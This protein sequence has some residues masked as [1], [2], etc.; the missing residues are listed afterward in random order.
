MLKKRIAVALA[1]MLCL[2]GCAATPAGSGVGASEEVSAGTDGKGAESAAPDGAASAEETAERGEG[3]Q[4]NA[5][6][7]EELQKMP[8]AGTGEWVEA[9]DGSKWF[10]NTGTFYDTFDTVT[11]LIAYTKTEEEFNRF[12]DLAHQEFQRL[13]RLYDNYQTYPGVTNLTTLNE[14]AGK[15]PVPVEE[16]LYSLL[17]FSVDQYEK[18]LGFVNVAMGA[19]L[20][21]WHDAR[22]AAGSEESE[23]GGASAPET[24][25]AAGSQSAAGDASTP[26]GGVLKVPAA[27]E[28]EGELPDR[29]A[30]EEAAKHANIADLVLD[31]KQKTVFFKDPLLKLDAGSV[32]KGYAT[33]RVAQKL[34]EAGLAHGIISAGGN[35]K[36]IGTPVTGKEHWTVGISHP[37]PEQGQIIAKV[38]VEGT[39][40]MVTSGDYQR[41]FTVDGKRYH[42]IIDPRTLMPAE[43]WISVSVQTEDSG[44]A[45]VLSTAFFIASREEAEQILKNY[46][47]TPI[48]VIWV[49][50]H[51]AVSSTPRIEERLQR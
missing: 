7:L 5:L 36:T 30:L 16:D 4:E 23:E 18:T 1:A 13:H 31:E 41:Y 8:M 39:S 42:H 46:A 2:S 40:S 50:A 29:K 27:S 20:A 14:E 48:D 22:E 43:P 34:V 10:K 6:T 44:L 9:S 33:E 32:A 51:F 35:V 28:L 37:R 38:S 45:D 26:K 17:Q 19:P 49:D 25:K 24:G 15:A 12:F 21:L 47:D 11:Q 3:S